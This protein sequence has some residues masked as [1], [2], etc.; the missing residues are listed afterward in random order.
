MLDPLFVAR[1]GKDDAAGK[2]TFVEVCS[3]KGA[4]LLTKAEQAGAIA[5]EPAP[6]KGIEIRGK[7][8]GAM[9]KLG[10]KWRAKDFA[11][12]GEGQTRLEKIMKD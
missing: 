1:V 2:A 6:A 11:E 8:E 10:D 4:D 7:I 3:Q 5:T 12:L 9:L